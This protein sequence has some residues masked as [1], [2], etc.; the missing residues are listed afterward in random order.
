MRTLLVQQEGRPAA[1]IAQLLRDIGHVVQC[2]R[3]EYEACSA[4]HKQVTELVLLDFD[5]PS[6][7]GL[8]LLKRIRAEDRTVPVLAIMPR[9]ESARWLDA[10]DAGASDLLIKPFSLVELLFRVAAI[11]RPRSGLTESKITHGS[12][13]LDSAMKVISVHGRRHPL[14]GPEYGVL[15][16]LLGRPGHVF[17]R[18][19][20][21]ERISISRDCDTNAPIASLIDGLREKIGMDSIRTVRGLGWMIPPAM[22]R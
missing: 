12:L 4:F 10:L 9:T 18:T 19:E 1:L 16:E 7:G 22:I 14:S 5:L 8:G 17:S 13:S 2:A 15:R 11:G 20:L 21:F 3:E 6:R